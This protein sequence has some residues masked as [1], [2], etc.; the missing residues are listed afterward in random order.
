MA[1]DKQ[2]LDRMR[3]H[4]LS[5]M[6]LDELVLLQVQ[7][8]QGLAGITQAVATAVQ[9]QGVQGVQVPSCFVCR[10]DG[11]LPDHAYTCGHAVCGTCAHK[12]P[13]CPFCNTVSNPI[14]IRF[15]P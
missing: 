3:G 5:G 10:G 2:L 13:A 1:A 14:E 8:H 11:A 7:A 12:M 9:Q 4:D 6:S 15:N